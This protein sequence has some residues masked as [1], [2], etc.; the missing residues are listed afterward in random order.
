[1]FKLYEKARE[2]NLVEGVCRA[3]SNKMGVLKEVEE[4]SIPLIGE[5]SG[6]PNMA[7]YVNTGYQVITS[8]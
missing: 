8:K 2:K 1:M 6:Q 5:M 4:E 3:C 7:Q